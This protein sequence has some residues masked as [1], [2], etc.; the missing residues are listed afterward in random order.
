MRISRNAIIFK[1]QYFFPSYVEPPSL[2][3]SFMP[4]YCMI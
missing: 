1:N 2:S 4:F 3:L